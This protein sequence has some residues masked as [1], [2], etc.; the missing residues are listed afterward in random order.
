MF[1]W[2]RLGFL[3]AAFC[4]LAPVGASAAT[5]F[6]VT[7]W[8]PYWRSATGTAD[9]LPHLDKLT[10]VNPFVYT[11]KT[12]GTFA[13]NG[14]LD[15]E[16][17]KSFIATAKEKKV[18]VIP[19]IMW[20][21]RANMYRILSNQKTRIALE[22]RIA[23]LVK[24]KGYDGID[25]D[26]ENKSAETRDYFSTFLKGLYMRMGKKWVMCTIE[27]R[28]PVADRY[29][30]GRAPADASVYAN[31]FKE[32]NKYCDRVRLMAYDQQRVDLALANSA[33]SSSRPYAPVADPAWVEKV[34]ALA[35][36]DIKKS[37]ILIGVPT[38]GY[39]YS[40][41]A[42]KGPL[43]PDG[44]PTPDYIYD[45]LW[46]FNPGYAI[47]LASQ[48]GITPERNA[49]GEMFFTYVP[50][51]TSTNPVSLGPGSAMLAAS[52][53]A[54]YAD[55]YNSNLSFRLM[56]WSDAQSIAGKIALAKKLGVR[57]ISIFKLD[58]GQDPALWG[59]L[60]GVKK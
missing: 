2:K 25:I 39:E 33:A 40:V 32:I 8:I 44:K 12:D 28:T 26:F 22:D 24:E 36:K 7:G 51:S 35:S 10:E 58:G 17:W 56:Q 53:A 11:V 60:A 41:T 57:G 46:T 31:D 9:T 37:K 23:A 54:A 18:R 42:Y 59:V 43:G 6:E 13:D 47:P 14:K 48:Y 3:V 45:I 55:M 21:D 4:F 34:V 52:A 49:E 30:D 19:T 27:A 16:P 1:M 29:P 20:S 15:A 38:Y 50:A 5:V